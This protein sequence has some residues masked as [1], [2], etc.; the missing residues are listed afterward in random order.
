MSLRHALRRLR[1]RPWL[2]AGA[3]GAFALAIGLAGAVFCLVDSVLWRPLSVVAPSGLVVAWAHDPTR[4]L[5]VVEVSYRNFED[6]KT[7]T[8]SFQRLAAMGSSNWATVMDGRGDPVR[9]SYAAVTAGFFDTLGVTPLL[10]RAFRDADEVPNSPRVVV[11]SHGAWME[12]FGGDASAIGASVTLDGQPHTVVGVMPQGFDFPRGAELWMPVVPVLAESSARWQVDALSSVGVLVV[13]GRLGEGATIEAAE[14]ELNALADAL[15][16]DGSAPR[17]GTGVVAVP[18]LRY[19]FGP[20]RPALWL[21]F[22]GVVMLLLVV[23]ANVSAMTLADDTGRQHE[24]AIRL[25]LGATRLSLARARLIETALLAGTGGGLGLLA[26]R[27]LASAIASLAPGGVLSPGMPPAGRLIAFVTLLTVMVAIVCGVVA[28]RGPLTSDPRALA[29][30][31][32][33]ALRRAATGRSLL[34]AIQVAV[35]VAL[36]LGAALSVQS[37]QAL[38]RIDLGFE[39]EHVVT[40]N[41]TPRS[42]SAISLGNRWFDDLLGQVSRLPTVTA[43]GGILL[44]PFAL[45][46]IGQET[47][48][49]LEHQPDVAE[50][51]REN[52]TLNYQVATPGYF[53]T[54]GITLEEGRLFNAAD[55]RR[56]PR[57]AIVSES[58]ATRLWPGRRAVGQR[59]AYPTFMPG[60]PGDEWRTVVG[61]VGDVRYR[62]VTDPRLDVYDAALQSNMLADEVVLRTSGDPL[63]AAAVVTSLVH[64]LD[65]QA[66]VD[67][68]SRLDDAVAGAMAP[69]RLG[70]A[71]LA[72]LATAATVVVAIGFVGLVNL[73]IAT[74]KRELAIRLAI[75]AT[76]RHIVH[77]L[78]TGPGFWI[79]AGLAAGLAAGAVGSLSLRGFLVGVEPLDATTYISVGVLTL[80]TIVAPALVMLRAVLAI[81]PRESLQRS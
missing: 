60:Q 56:A 45:G 63:A 58:T 33:L 57:V 15:E 80:V 9:F 52:P 35:S 16:L 46:P 68:V 48:V 12:R 79:G 5:P 18:W 50:S 24:H 51:R 29:G 31:R 23:C 17:F 25:A 32:D 78:L 4:N 49:L 20:L 30:A 41:V 74:R 19:V 71:V 37:Y 8:T 64:R 70:A 42:A 28:L 14:A 6:W 59:L 2:L 73:E 11:L 10:G 55:D 26:A 75:G 67:R 22:V 27:P 65:P 72:L 34:L 44:S 3:T 77:A 62:G 13:V 40:L 47:R 1:S 7:G 53:D 66:V 39:P 69:W 36:L 81:D 61:V 76:A 38:G 54:L 43:A 21:V